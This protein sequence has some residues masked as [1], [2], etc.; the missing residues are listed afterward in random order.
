[1]VID[2]KSEET[3][4][5]EFQM[6]EETPMAVEIINQDRKKFGKQE[7]FPIS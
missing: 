7:F 4:I 1:M 6:L 5:I 3:E 2:N